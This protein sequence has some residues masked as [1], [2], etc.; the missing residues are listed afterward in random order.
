AGACAPMNQKAT[1][2][3]MN[4]TASVLPDIGSVAP[5][6]WP[7]LAAAT[8]AAGG[9]GAAGG[10]AD[11]L[12]AGGGQVTP[13]S[14]TTVVPRITSSSMLTLMPPSLVLHT[15]SVNRRRLVA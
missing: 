4:T 7:L 2:P 5:W 3:T 1:A 13:P 11:N 6:P 12:G 10:A 8:G 14:L 15:S 9:F